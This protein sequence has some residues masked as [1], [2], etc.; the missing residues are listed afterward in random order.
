[1]IAVLMNKENNSA[2]VS[3]IVKEALV[4]MPTEAEI[5]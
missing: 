2:I 5:A 3:S 4:M 1:M